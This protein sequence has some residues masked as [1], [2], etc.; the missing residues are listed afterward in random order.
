MTKNE[1][2]KK[3]QAVES[4]AKAL[5]EAITELVGKDPSGLIGAHAFAAQFHLQD[6]LNRVSNITMF[7]AQR[8][9]ENVEAAV[10]KAVEES[11]IRVL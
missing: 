2:A 3:I 11:K 4:G 5:S 6:A 9:D 7:L 1:L 8:V 10:D